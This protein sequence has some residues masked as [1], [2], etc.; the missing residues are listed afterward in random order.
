MQ[1]NKI[2]VTRVASSE[3]TSRESWCVKSSE[4]GTASSTEQNKHHRRREFIIML[5]RM[6][7]VPGSRNSVAEPNK[8]HERVHTYH[9]RGGTCYHLS[10]HHNKLRCCCCFL[11]LFLTGKQL[12]Q[13]SRRKYQHQGV[14]A[15]SILQSKTLR[16][17]QCWTKWR[18]CNHFLRPVAA[19]VHTSA[20]S[21]AN[22]AAALQLPEQQQ[23]TT[24]ADTDHLKKLT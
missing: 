1:Q 16:F 20:A 21:P 17:T 2:S 14:S 3:P 23:G 12:Y 24:P 6:L 18:M 8:H 11:F 10:P 19:I 4:G 13:P 7:G 15:V 9:E 5:G 22:L